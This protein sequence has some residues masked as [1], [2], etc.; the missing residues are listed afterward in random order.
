MQQ[1]MRD[2][3]GFARTDAGFNTNRL[4]AKKNVSGKINNK[5]DLKPLFE[6]KKAPICFSPDGIK[7]AK[8]SSMRHNKH[9]LSSEMLETQ[10]RPQGTS[11]NLQ[12]KWE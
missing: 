8:L 11:M 12:T 6:I 4:P 1:A 5:K 9:S 3:R 10:I 2:L 7:E